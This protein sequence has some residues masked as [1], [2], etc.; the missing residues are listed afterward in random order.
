MRRPHQKQFNLPSINAQVLPILWSYLMR[1]YRTGW[2]LICLGNVK[3]KDRR[4]INK[5][6]LWAQL[7]WAMNT[8]TL[9][10]YDRWIEPIVPIGSILLLFVII[11]STLAMQKILI[12]DVQPSPEQISVA[13]SSCPSSAQEIQ[14]QTLTLT[15]LMLEKILKKC[16]VKIANQ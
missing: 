11:F 16:N 1:Q 2:W 9:A 5:L 12:D 14:M 15:N 13:M 8:K 10:F 4:N 6:A 7:L 3:M